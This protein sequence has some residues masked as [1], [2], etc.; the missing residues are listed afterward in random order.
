VSATIGWFPLF[1]YSKSQSPIYEPRTNISEFFRFSSL[2]VGRVLAFEFSVVVTIT[3]YF[4]NISI[5][6]VS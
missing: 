6:P 4:L 3:A 5:V 2:V 1:Q